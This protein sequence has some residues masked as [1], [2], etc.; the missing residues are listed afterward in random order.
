MKQRHIIAPEAS[1]L[2][3]QVLAESSPQDVDTSVAIAKHRR[4]L[5]KFETKEQLLYPVEKIAQDKLLIMNI[6]YPGA[7]EDFPFIQD[8]LMRFVTKVYPNAKG[9]A[10]Y[11]DEPRNE[12][13]SW[14]AWER[15]KKMKVRGLRH[16][17]VEQDTEYFSLLEQLGE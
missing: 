15:H 1:K 17:V 4:N 16:L 3:E 10:L 2:K 7:D 6:K 12:T 14:R 5:A 8:V 9:G 13:Q 11:V